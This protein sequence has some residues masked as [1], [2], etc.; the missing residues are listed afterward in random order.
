[1]DI[2]TVVAYGNQGPPPAAAPAG[3]AGAPAAEVRSPAQDAPPPSAR[4][5]QAAVKELERVVQ[6]KASNL[7]FSI[8][9]DSGH[10]IVKV[11][12]SSTGDLIRQIPSQEVVDIAR[13]IDRMQALLMRQKA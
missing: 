6:S 7:Q 10:T 2:S 1:M 13:N 3:G 12:D 9:D 4:Q 5:V 11:I 8:D